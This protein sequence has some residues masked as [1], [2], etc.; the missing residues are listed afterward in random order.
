MAE[1]GVQATAETAKVFPRHGWCSA[2]SATTTHSTST[3]KTSSGS[4][5]PS[6]ARRVSSGSTTDRNNRRVARILEPRLRRRGGRPNQGGAVLRAPQRQA[7]GCV[8]GVRRRHVARRA[9]Y[10]DRG[11][12]FR[13]Q[14]L[15]V[16]HRTV[17]REL[18]KLIRVGR[19]PQGDGQPRRGPTSSAT[20]SPSRST[21][22]ARTTRRRTRNCSTSLADRTCAS[23]ASTSKS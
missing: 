8:P 19:V 9:M 20:A 1:N 16:G 15:P 2:R 3:S 13:R 18:A 5:T 22:W 10:A 21:T 11:E 6:S 14:R 4:S 17:G 7:E 12:D 23:R